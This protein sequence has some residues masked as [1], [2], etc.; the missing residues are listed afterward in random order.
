MD[1]LLSFDQ[2]VALEQRDHQEFAKAIRADIAPKLLRSPEFL[3]VTKELEAHNL[4]VIGEREVLSG[5]TFG[6]IFKIR[7]RDILTG[8]EQDLVERVYTSALRYQKIDLALNQK[9]EIIDLLDSEE[10]A[11]HALRG[12]RGIPRVY[13]V[14]NGGEKG[15]LLEQYIDGVDFIT[16]LNNGDT[17]MIG[18]ILAKIKAV[19]SAAAEKGYILGDVV[20]STIMIDAK[21]RQPY[22]MDWY[23]RSEGSIAIDG[24]IREQ[25]L[26]GLKAIDNLAAE[27]NNLQAKAA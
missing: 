23:Y 4:A 2:V 20:N 9:T 17:E 1:K 12:I 24:P 10:K 6:P 14:V 25:Y 16:I 11:L 18:E 19:Y 3:A 8:E 7:A 26:D 21:T 15:S 13:G 22:L 27:V 5:G